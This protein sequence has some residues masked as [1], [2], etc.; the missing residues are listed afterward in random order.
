LS[1]DVKWVDTLAKAMEHV[2]SGK[3][4]VILLDLMLPDSNGFD[5]FIKV[6]AQAQDTPIIILTGSEDEMLAL[7]AVSEGAQDY[8]PKGQFECNMF[9]HAI[10][11]ALERSRIQKDLQ[12]A[13]KDLEAKVRE[14][15]CE[16]QTEKD[17]LQRVL[18]ESVDSLGFA[19]AKRDPYTAGHQ[20]RVAKLSIAIAKSIGLSEDTTIG[21]SLAALVHDI[22][23]IGVP[24]AIL[25]KPDQLS[26]NEMNAIRLHSEAGHSILKDIEFSWPIAEIVF[27]H[28]ERINGSGYPRGLSGDAILMESKIL[29]VADVVEAMA[30]DRPYRPAIGIQGALEE[31]SCKRGILYEPTVV[32]ACLEL[33]QKNGFKFE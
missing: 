15:T 32:D 12:N 28:H 27:Q 26:E 3:F 23:K 19:L 13:K 7:N 4:D 9:L 16:L 22:G 5:T 6:K 18:V 30:S 24:L 25:V 8:I 14:R 31:L 10:A 1:F 17:R 29:C 11:Y 20:R 2:T 33:F 21:L